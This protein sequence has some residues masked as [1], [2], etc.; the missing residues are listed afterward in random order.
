MMPRDTTMTKMAIW[1]LHIRVRDL[2]LGLRV[3]VKG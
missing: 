1:Y 3:R 2:G